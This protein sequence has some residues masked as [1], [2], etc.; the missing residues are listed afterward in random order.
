MGKLRPLSATIVVKILQ[1]Y[2]FELVRQ[3]GSHLIMQKTLENDTITVP[4][5]N[6]KEIQVGTLSSIIRQSNLNRKA[7][8]K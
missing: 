2:G 8:E 5:P 6:H 7:F 4:V 3:K 1:S